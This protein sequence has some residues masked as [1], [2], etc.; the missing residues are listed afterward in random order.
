MIF[1][2]VISFCYV[3]VN[4]ILIFDCCFLHLSYEGNH[5]EMS[6]KVRNCTLC[7]AL[8]VLSYQNI[9]KIRLS[10][11]TENYTT[12][13]LNPTFILQNWGLQG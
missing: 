3:Y 5:I 9:T 13:N 11:Y 8:Q 6:H 4:K 10:K 7:H 1:R 12:K 2:H